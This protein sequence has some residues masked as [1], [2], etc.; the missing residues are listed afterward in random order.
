M[1]LQSF[2]HRIRG[3]LQPETCFSGGW[4]LELYHRSPAVFQSA[5]HQL[6]EVNLE[7]GYWNLYPFHCRG[8]MH[9]IIT[10]IKMSPHKNS[11]S[12]IF[13]AASMTLNAEY[14]S[15]PFSFQCHFKKFLNNMPML[16]LSCHL[17]IVHLF[18]QKSNSRY[19]EVVQHIQAIL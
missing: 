8:L 17:S 14:Y 6:N 18:Q 19:W 1:H 2:E 16:Y 15:P 10:S 13:Y 3:S 4:T 7:K 11:V 12:F 5:F 9:F